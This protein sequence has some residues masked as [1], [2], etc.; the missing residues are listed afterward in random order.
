MRALAALA[1]AFGWTAGAM[2]EE[3]GPRVFTAADVFNLEWA[4]DPQVSPDGKMVAYVRMGYDRLK[5][6]PR[7]QIWAVD[8]ASGAHRP[9]IAGAG[10][11]GG[12][13]WSPKG[14][15]LLFVAAEAG[16]PEL[17]VHYL[18]DG[19]STPLA[20]LDQPAQ[21]ASWSPDGRF[22]AFAMLVLSEPPSLAKPPKPPD[23]ADWAAPVRVFDELVLRNDGAGW[24][25]KGDSHIFVVPAEGGAP[26][27]LTKGD[28][29][30][31]GPVWLS[32]DT[33]LVSGED[34]PDR[35]LD[36]LES[37]IYAIARADGART[38]LTTRD[39]PDGFP[40]V[41]PDGKAIAYAGHEDKRL[42]YRLT[43][44]S[45]MGADGGGARA[46]TAGYDRA[47]EGDSLKWAP[48]GK[49]LLALVE[50]A[51]ELSLVSFG[52]DGRPATLARDVGG[53]TMGRPYASGAFSIG[54]PP[55]AP[56]IAYTQSRNARPAELAILAG[57][58]TATVTDLNTDALG[59]IA[60]ARVEEL[61][62]PSSA[63]GL[64][65]EAWVALPPGFK[66]D[67][68]F[69]MILEIHGGPWAMY[70]PFWSAEIQ[71]YAAEGY[72]VVWAN[73]RGSTGYG[74]AF[75]QAIDLAYPGQDYDDLMSVVDA[76]IAKNYVDPERLFVTGGSGGGVLTA[77]IVGKTDRFKAAASI[78]P[79]INWTSMALA[80]DISAFVTRNWLRA[81]P[82]ENQELYW[83]LSPLSL[84]GEVKTPT[85]LMVGEED[86]R[87]PAWEAEQYYTALK[88][89]G[90]ET[91]LIRV[92][93]APHNIAGRPS[94]LIAKADN[95]LGWFAKHDAKAEKA[96]A[97]EAPAP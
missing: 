41:S 18:A 69:P 65:I 43:E 29:D 6:R 12:P 36:P 55:G 84:V 70:G 56:V 59:H 62:T 15:R 40:A 75:A 48:D 61:T 78:K 85:M 45:V 79:V 60:L 95:I 87:T 8:V 34:A 97:R 64:P 1:L 25:K 47:V 11:Y 71:R 83:R 46:L 37:D 9:L 5:D 96:R 77:W 28:A 38:K 10:S 93:G 22:I 72:V 53:A 90:V 54:G 19:R 94:H 42:A 4:A 92:P 76:V 30:F 51:G 3:A 50:D 74:D 57:G 52:L 49:A 73:P 20:Q 63:G 2:A 17:R 35:D 21:G 26:R 23:G 58:K 81:Q 31:Q 24:A 14:D 91:A 66:A 67:K 86:W 33:L 16:K 80:S 88:L 27:Q 68:S 13:R 89:R 39:G 7:G 82:W 44:L 32:N